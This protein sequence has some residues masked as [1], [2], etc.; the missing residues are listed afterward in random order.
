MKFFNIS[1]FF[2]LTT[3]LQFCC[4]GK[5]HI[6]SDTAKTIIYISDPKVA[7]GSILKNCQQKIVQALCELQEIY[8]DKNTCFCLTSDNS[9]SQSLPFETIFEIITDGKGC[10]ILFSKENIQK[11]VEISY[12]VRTSGFIPIENNVQLT[13]SKPKGR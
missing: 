1:L 12:P 7:D 6:I 4:F 3:S 13:V 2:W 9:S 5:N 11:K 10:E 8:P